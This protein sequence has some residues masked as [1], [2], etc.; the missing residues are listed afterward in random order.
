MTHE[1]ASMFQKQHMDKNLE[2]LIV[3]GR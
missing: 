1:L 2:G 3:A